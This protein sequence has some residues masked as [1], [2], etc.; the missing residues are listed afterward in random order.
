M[1]ARADD[2]RAGPRD[3][4]RVDGDAEEEMNTMATLSKGCASE[5]AARRAVEALRAT[6]APPRHTR[7]LM[8]RPL[9]R[10][11]S[12]ANRPAESPELSGTD[13]PSG[14]TRASCAGAARAPAASRPA[15]S[16]AIQTNGARAPSPTLSAS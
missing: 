6:G 8:S 11:T 16:P 15:A 9:P 4:A 12:A 3:R 14:P 7:L 5:D 13:T 2:R 10:A 1:R